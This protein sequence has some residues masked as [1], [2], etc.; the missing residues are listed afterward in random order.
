MKKTFDNL[1]IMVGTPVHRD[2]D[3]NYVMSLLELQKECTFRKIPFSV[4]FVKSSL[5]TQGRQMIVSKFLESNCSHLLFIDSD[6]SFNYTMFEKMLLA[7]KEIILVPY[8]VKGFDKN[9]LKTLIEKGSTLDINLLGNQYTINFKDNLNNIQIENGICELAR[10]PAGFMLIKKEVFK[11]L[12]EK[13]PD[14]I[15]KQPTLIDGKLIEY[16]SLY[17]FFDTHFRK[18]DNTYHGEDFWFCMLCTDIGIKIYGLIDEYISHHGDYSYTGRLIDELSLT[19]KE[20][21]KQ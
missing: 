8:P 2:L 1:N 7:D 6:I 16:D 18:E 14:Y 9:K 20:E 21:I 10:G 4:N 11:K 15:I 19:K 12:I 13:Y 3:L 5:V 17:N